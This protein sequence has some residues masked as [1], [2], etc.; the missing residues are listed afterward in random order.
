MPNHQVRD[1]VFRDYFNNTERLLSLGNALLGT[2]YTDSSSIVI[3]TLDGNLYNNIK[4][5]ISFLLDNHWLIL[6]EH[7]STINNNMPFRMLLYVSEL[8][9][10]YA[11]GWH[12]KLY[13]PSLQKL[14]EPEFFVFYDGMDTS[15]DHRTLRLSDAF[16]K[17]NSKLELQVECF[18]L[19]N[20]LSQSIKDCCPYLNEYSLFSSV[21]KDY[22]KA[23]FTPEQAIRA[24]IEYAKSNNVML[25]YIL[26]KESE[27]IDMFGFEWNENEYR[28]AIREDAMEEGIKQGIEQG[29]LEG[30]FDLIK[31][32]LS[33]GTPIETIEKASGLS[34]EAILNLKQP[35]VQH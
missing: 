8:Y 11:A 15:F 27:V 19:N 28:E 18:N 13:R 3:N 4:N 14:P 20:G 17:P 5:D 33:L 26:E 31:S 24:T 32:L 9:K 6:I 2:N 16:G 30:K 34:K 25:N 29:K 22:L 21:Y 23:G 12:Q 35:A 7:Q 1:T 10:R